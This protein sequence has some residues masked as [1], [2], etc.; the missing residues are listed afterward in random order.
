MINDIRNDFDLLNAEFGLARGKD[1][2]RKRIMEKAVP[3]R[4]PALESE[5]RR[6]QAH[7]E[8]LE[9]AEPHDAVSHIFRKQEE[10]AADEQPASQADIGQEDD[11]AGDDD[12][13]FSDDG[14][15]FDSASADDTP[16][17][18]AI[19][20]VLVS[21]P[22]EAAQV[23]PEA[24]SEVFPNDAQAEAPPSPEPPSA[25][26][27]G[28][29]AMPGLWRRSAGQSPFR[30]RLPIRLRPVVLA[31]TVM[32]VMAILAVGLLGTIQPALQ[33]AA[34]PPAV[35]V[36]EATPGGDE[37]RRSPAYQESVEAANDAGTQTALAEGADAFL[38]TVESLS[39]PVRERFVEP[40]RNSLAGGLSRSGQA[41]VAVQ[42]P[43]EAAAWQLAEE[44]APFEQ[45][46]PLPPI[47]ATGGF[48]PDVAGEALNPM[49]EHLTALAERPMPRMGSQSFAAP[50][51]P[52][53]PPAPAVLAGPVP[54]DSLQR[55]GLRVGDM[56]RAR[57]LNGLNSD[58][59]GPA[60]AEIVEGPLAGSRVSGSFSTMRSAAGLAL[61]FS[62][63]SLPDG[64]DLPISAIG[65]SPWTGGKVTRSRLDPRYAQRYG[66]LVF[67]G[68]I[69][70]ATG[71]ITGSGTHTTVSNGTVIVERDEATRHQ[72]IAAG[73]G[74]AAGAVASDLAS[75]IPDGALIEL[76]RGAPIVVLFTASGQPEAHPL[77]PGAAAAGLAP[78]GE[79]IPGL[80]PL[81]GLAGI[82]ST[83]H[84]AIL[85]EGV[86]LPA[87]Q[88]LER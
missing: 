79:Q 28:I 76:D 84:P 50:R 69:T 15:T 2:A 83:G 68:A 60:I 65:L 26:R 38:P 40:A 19:P 9:N 8:A 23:A 61:D 3:G 30:L 41:A 48:A 86:T 13:A 25:R 32:A 71:A 31:A 21:P 46:E 74:Q 37:Q 18:D 36:L 77:P 52:Q 56:A 44:A 43:D 49:L 39:S 35:P 73:L 70:G 58:L 67:S 17:A 80:A 88:G 24:R 62:T 6:N 57:M 4:Q 53:A 47:P 59:P 55:L 33:P 72:I 29:R 5:A 81:P 7:A 42:P 78:A 63:I 16:P 34:P 27:P 1:A 10:P 64:R 85:P 82:V 66:G 75:R 20:G 54:E 22:A 51:A 12:Q 45:F 11:A 14:G 87:Q